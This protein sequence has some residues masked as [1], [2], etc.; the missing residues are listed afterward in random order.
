VSEGNVLYYG[1]NLDVL[2]QHVADASVDL[3]YLDPPFNSNQ[4]FNVLFGDH[5]TKSAAQIKA[6]SDTWHW[7]QTA[8]EAYERT[9][10]HGGDV[11]RTMQAF[12]STLGHANLLA[13]LSMMAPRLLDLRRVLKATGSLYLHCDP[14]AS[15]Y[16]KLLLDAVFGPECFRNEIIW[17]R[18]AA[19]GDAKRKLGSIHDVILFYT[20]KADGYYFEPARRAPDAEYTARF[21][22]DDAD[23]RGPYRLAPL[24]SPNPRPNLTYEY[25]GHDPPAKGWRVSREVMEELDAEGR[26][27]FPKKAGG[28]I[29][30]KHYLNEQE[31]PNVGDVW[32]DIP[33]L[34]AAS[35]ERLGYPTQ[36]PEALLQRIVES[37]S[38]PG[39]VVLDPFCGCGTTIAVAQRLGRS[40]IG[41]DVTYLATALI[42]GRLQDQFGEAAE[43]TVVG[44][45]VSVE[46]AAVLAKSDPYQFQFW[47][48]GLVGARPTEEKKGADQGIDGR[49]YFHDEP[50]GKTKQII[51]SVKAGKTGPSHVRDLRGV[52]ERE[53]AQ[54]GVLLTFNEPT[55]PM[56]SEA[57]DAGFYKSP[58]WN[59]SYPR[60]Q[61]YTVGELLAGKRIEY[62]AQTGVTFKKAPKSEPESPKTDAMF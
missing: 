5:G 52:V 38:E 17:Q 18:T 37:S 25:K 4:S 57:A 34:Q 1:D 30:R 62:P 20:A 11:S 51:I 3:V 44:E 39:H 24:D 60:L 46:D 2:G 36:K 61:I 58:G 42:K 49:I 33:P 45:P 6:F 47:S 15:H 8:A 21:S 43:F 59:K 54:I 53:D 23:G 14:T 48:L 28:R 19:K 55:Q 40:W 41:I 56:R 22:L 10:E 13:Y 35:A 12:R 32:T 50:G 16:L 27:A 29:A 9:V 31:W 7:D 26:L